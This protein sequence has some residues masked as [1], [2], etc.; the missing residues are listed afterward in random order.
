LTQ[1]I[2]RDK[3]ELLLRMLVL[4]VDRCVE[5]LYYYYLVCFCC[6]KS[7][8]RNVEEREGEVKMQEPAAGLMVGID[9]LAKVGR[10]PVLLIEM[11]RLGSLVVLVFV[12]TSQLTQRCQS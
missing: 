9:A 4:P 2:H 5:K 11:T 8:G 12:F 10:T 1:H 3:S 6:L 7:T